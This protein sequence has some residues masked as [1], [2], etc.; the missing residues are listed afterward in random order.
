[1]NISFYLIPKSELCYIYEEETV[2]KGL[3]TI[4]EKGFQAVPVINKEGK[5]CGTVTEGDF[6][7][8]LTIRH[9]NDSDE[10]MHFPL[11]MLPKRWDYKAVSVEADIAELD[12]YI[13]NQNF[14]PVVDSRG[15]F[16]GIITRKVIIS[17]LLKRYHHMV[18]KYG[19]DEVRGLDD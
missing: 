15:I 8:A 4:H 17:V 7:W 11:S 16:I 19:L 18:D 3:D 6:L 9:Y 5:Y 1:M 10:L 12:Q 13:I 2:G 14:V